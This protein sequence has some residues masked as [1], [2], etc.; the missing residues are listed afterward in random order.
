MA[1]EGTSQGV[2]ALPLPPSLRQ[3][4]LSS[5]FTAVADLR[6]ISP[7]DLANEAGLE[8]EEALHV[9]KQVHSPFGEGRAAVGVSARELLDRERAR[10]SIVSFCASVDDLL[11]GG[12][13]PGEITEFCGVPGIGKTQLGI[14][15]AVSVQLPE[16]FGGLAGEAMYIDTEGSFTVERAVDL[17]D[18]AVAHVRA[19]A[20]DREADVQAAAATF[21]RE[22]VLEGIHFFR[23]HDA[24]ELLAMIETLPGYLAQFPRVKLVVIDSIA[25]H[26]RQSFEDMALRTRLLGQLMQNLTRL[27]DSRQIA[28]TTMNQV[29]TKFGKD[30]RAWQAPALGDSFAHACTTRV[31]LF[32]Q[33]GQRFAHLFKSPRLPQDTAAFAVTPDGIRG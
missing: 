24:T 27:A 19:I 32:W 15:L 13:A 23:V 30:G 10:R 22:R 17:T 33:E 4:L 1:S 2:V 12:V 6:N 21:T 29:T 3:R 11:G 14:Q 16:A 20:R 28:V 5:G 9:L 25:F 18:A 7:L 8:R 31:I 26:F